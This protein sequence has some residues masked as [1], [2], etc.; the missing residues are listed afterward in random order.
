MVIPINDTAV[1]A[2]GGYGTYTVEESRLSDASE[3]VLQQ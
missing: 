2:L 3:D 1:E